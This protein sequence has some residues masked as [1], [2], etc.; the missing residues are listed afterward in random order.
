MIPTNLENRT[1]GSIG[2][3]GEVDEMTEVVEVFGVMKKM[4]KKMMKKFPILIDQSIICQSYYISRFEK[5]EGCDTA[6]SGC[7]K[8]FE[9]GCN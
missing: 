5:C 9:M 8:I 1:I 7:E 6:I 3:F 2:G 4:S